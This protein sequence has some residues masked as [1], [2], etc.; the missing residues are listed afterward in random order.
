M[1]KKVFKTTNQSTGRLRGT[2]Q[3]VP[4]WEAIRSELDAD[5]LLLSSQEL[6]IEDDEIIKTYNNHGDK[7]HIPRTFDVPEA[8]FQTST[9]LLIQA[10]EEG[11]SDR[12][13]R[14]L[15]CGL[16]VHARSTDFMYRGFTAIHVA[17]LY[18]LINIVEI[19]LEYSAN[20]DD[21][22][23]TGK[24]RPL[25]FAAGSRKRSMVKFLIRHGAQIDAKARNDVQPIHEASWSGSIEVLDA[26]IEAGAPVDCSD[27]FRYQPLH[28]ATTTTNQPDVINYLV[29]KNADVNAEISDG[30]RAIH[31]SCK[32][33]STNLT[34][35]ST[36]LALGAKTDFDDGT[37]S[38]LV[39]AINSENTVAVE[40]LLRHG[41]G[42]KS[43]S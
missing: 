13:K 2:V 9:A 33:D 5:S 7:D 6:N 43:P 16:D 30:L 32:T 26:L 36:L 4:D 12:V 42:P 25:H 38:A 39:T 35:L 15:V 22:D 20:I 41:R 3:S 11:N 19:L 10:C 21:E 18:G 1:I 37:E 31:L 14:L 23:L 29:R 27:S 34:N 24:R 28:W 8:P 40:M 17:A